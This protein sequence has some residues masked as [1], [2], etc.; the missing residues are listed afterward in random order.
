MSNQTSDIYELKL[1][2]VYIDP[3]G[4]FAIMRVPGGW[5]Y[6]VYAIDNHN[7]NSIAN[8]V[9]VPFCRMVPSS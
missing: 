2:K 3:L 7:G 4:R 1:H 9:F 8:T 5:L 6:T